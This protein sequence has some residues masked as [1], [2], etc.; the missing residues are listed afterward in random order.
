MTP[1]VHSHSL[2]QLVIK[3]ENI[4]KLQNYICYLSSHIKMQIS[5][6][7]KAVPFYSL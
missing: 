2:Y 4:Q 1:S 6:G 5:L 7:F 3:S